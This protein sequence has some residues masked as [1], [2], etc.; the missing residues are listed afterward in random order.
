VRSTR[1]IVVGHLFPDYLNIYADRG[2]IAVLSAR[3]AWRGY[4]LEVRSL[5]GDTAI[6]P[7]EHDLFY[8]GGGQD[9]E[10][11]LI[12]PELAALGPGLREAVAAGAAALAVCGGYQLFGRFYRDQSGEELPG[13]GLLP[14]HTV[15]G[16]RRMIGDVLLECELERGQK[17]TLA[18]FENHAGR[19]YLDPGAEPLGRVVAGFGNDGESGYE[20]CHSGRV[21]GTYLHGPLLPRNPWFADWLLAQAISHRTGEAPTLE[22][23]GDKLEAE[24]QAVSAARAQARGG[25]Y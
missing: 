17:R 2:N 24:A 9:R 22:P 12:A 25:R 16:S 13:I 10:Q 14:L 15:A 4:A 3:A 5:A 6:P 7:G 11:A 18:G 20:G 23:L 1:R 8:I 19:T 21:V